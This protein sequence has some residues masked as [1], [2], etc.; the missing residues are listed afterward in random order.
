MAVTS[1]RLQ[2]DL[3]KSLEEMAHRMNRSKNWLINQA[4]REFL[5]REALEQQRWRETLEALESADKG[6]VVEGETVH[7]WLE[8]W[9]EDNEG[10][11]PKR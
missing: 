1:I 11:P 4:V 5:Q 8:S 7:A 3:E 9:G 10:V 6:K 2:S